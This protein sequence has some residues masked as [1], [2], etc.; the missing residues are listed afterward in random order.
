MVVCE[1]GWAFFRPAVGE[2]KEY[3]LSPELYWPVNA[4]GSYARES[5]VQLTIGNLMLG[6]RC[7]QSC[8]PPSVP[9]AEAGQ[10]LAQMDALREQWRAHWARK[11]SREFS[12]RLRLWQD[13]VEELTSSALP[14][15]ADYA[16]KV[17]WRAILS[18]LEPE[19]ETM[20][21]AEGL[22]LA[23][24]DD[25]LRSKG[26]PG[27]FVWEAPLAVAF[28]AEEYWFLYQKFSV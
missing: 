20:A 13:Y 12:A 21:P 18:L 24:L 28:P 7:L 10:L 1:R 11:A 17:R 3:L 16:F 22:L 14:K 9:P 8:L 19:C 25:R 26:V 5:V 15:A 23:A 6:Q 27:E 2:L 4:A